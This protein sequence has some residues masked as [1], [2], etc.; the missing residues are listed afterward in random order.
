MCNIAHAVRPLNENLKIPLQQ[1]W[2]VEIYT[3]NSSPCLENVEFLAIIKLLKTQSME[4]KKD[5]VSRRGKSRNMG[6][7]SEDR[8]RQGK[9]GPLNTSLASHLSAQNCLPPAAFLLETKLMNIIIFYHSG[10]KATDVR[11]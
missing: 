9:K 2:P 3:V 11:F 6:S 4:E 1:Q 10:R 7:L 8:G 5:Q